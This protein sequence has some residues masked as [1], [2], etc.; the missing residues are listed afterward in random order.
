MMLIGIDDELGPQVFKCDPS[1]FYVG[2][3]ATASGAKQQESINHLEKKLKKDPVLSNE[4]AIEVCQL[5]SRVVV[6]K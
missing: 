6:Y 3:K 2:Y 5:L 4:D 1:G